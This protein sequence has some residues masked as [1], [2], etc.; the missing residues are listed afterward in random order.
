MPL[1]ANK[2]GNELQ[3]THNYS[4]LL[5]ARNA[6]PCKPVLK[7]HSCFEGINETDTLFA[8]GER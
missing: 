3:P 1:Q 8:V 7:L 5:D 6:T 2:L 4:S